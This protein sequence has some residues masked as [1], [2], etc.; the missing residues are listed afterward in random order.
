MDDDRHIEL[1]RQLEEWHCIVIVGIVPLQT[2]GD[3]R[4][5]EAVLLYRAFEFAQKAVAAKY[6]S[7]CKSVD[8]IVL[9]LLGRDVAIVPSDQ[10]QLLIGIEI[11]QDVQW[12]AD[13][14]GVDASFLLRFEHV[15]HGVGLR[16]AAVRRCHHL[17]VEVGVDERRVVRRREDVRM[18]IDDHSSGSIKSSAVMHT[19]A[20]VSRFRSSQPLLQ[21]DVCELRVRGTKAVPGHIEA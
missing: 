5:F 2:R 13:D 16:P 12:I 7:R 20:L 15:F 9:F 4:A 19:C 14:G 18:K 1:G 8:E 21:H 3:P 11:A 17:V 10:I 6:D